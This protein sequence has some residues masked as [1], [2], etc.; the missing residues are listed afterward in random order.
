MHC[1]RKCAFAAISET[2]DTR[3]KQSGSGEQ[4]FPHWQHSRL[5]RPYVNAIDQEREKEAAD[6]VTL[7]DVK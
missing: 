6:M 7:A 1:N 5:A 2:P 4:F 3:N